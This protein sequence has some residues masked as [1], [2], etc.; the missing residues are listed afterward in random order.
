MRR[1]LTVAAA[2]AALIVLMCPGPMSVSMAT[3]ASRAS[4]PAS[5]Q[6]YVPETVVHLPWGS[7]DWQAG[8]KDADESAPEGPMSFTVS[9]WGGIYLLDQVNLRVLMFSPQGLPVGQVPVHS[10]TYQDIEVSAGGQIVLLDRLAGRCLTVLDAGGKPV[11]RTGIEGGAIPEGGGVTAMFLRDDGVWLEVE[12]RYLVRLLDGSCAPTSQQVF[13]GRFAP[14]APRALRAQRLT[15]SSAEIQI[16]DGSTGGPVGRAVMGWGS[17]LYRI[18]WIEPDR[19]GNIVMMF[20]LLDELDP[21]NVA[22]EEV[23]AYVASSDLQTVTPLFSTPDTIREWE[24]FRE[25]KVLADGTV[26]QMAFMDDGVRLIQW[27]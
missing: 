1:M 22:R 4:G 26:L 25:F 15:P 9:P 20:H 12:H 14:A 16:V 27:K 7:G 19:H 13:P 18:V 24:Q 21:V 8:K 17:L 11:S 2:G 5:P 3:S 23:A 6:S 10:D